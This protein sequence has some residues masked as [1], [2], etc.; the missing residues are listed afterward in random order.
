MK[1]E[2]DYIQYLY[3]MLESTTKG[4]SFGKGF[5]LEKFKKDERTQFA[6]IR[7]IEIIGEASKKVPQSIKDNF[8]EIPWREIGGM[9]DKLVHDYFGVNID[10]VWKTVKQDL[11]TLK[12]LL[13]TIL[14]DLES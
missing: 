7:T 3:D 1:K 2:R 9:R 12:K 10:V 14:K 6:I 11:P 13:K 5:T 4:I 8:K